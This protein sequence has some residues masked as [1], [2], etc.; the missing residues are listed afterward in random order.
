MGINHIVQFGS[1]EFQPVLDIQHNIHYEDFD[2]P[3]EQSKNSIHVRSTSLEDDYAQIHEHLKLRVYSILKDLFP[4]IP[5]EEESIR[6]RLMFVVKE[7]VKNSIE[8]IYELAEET[9]QPYI[10]R[11]SFQMG[12]NDETGFQFAIED[13]GIGMTDEQQTDFIERFQNKKQH[14]NS[15]KDERFTVNGAFAR[16][17]HVIGKYFSQRNMTL[18]LENYGRNNGVRLSFNIQPHN[19]DYFLEKEHQAFEDILY[20]NEP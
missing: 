1:V 6:L 9:S 5:P 2:P 11:I 8:A 7:F 16:A 10:G 15:M 12:Y 3:F 17:T 19:I 14:G 13:N 4:K 18:F 20:G